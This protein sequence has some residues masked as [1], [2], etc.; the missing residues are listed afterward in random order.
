MKYVVFFSSCKKLT[1]ILIQF[2][3]MQNS[4]R[5]TEVVT[6]LNQN[7][8]SSGNIKMILKVRNVIDRTRV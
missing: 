5:L 8:P 2:Q 3:L 1:Y 4:C 7:I 6:L